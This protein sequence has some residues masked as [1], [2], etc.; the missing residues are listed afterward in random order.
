MSELSSLSELA[1]FSGRAGS[2]DPQRRRR[3]LRALTAQIDAQGPRRTVTE[4][5]GVVMTLSA[6]TRRLVL[7]PV[8]IDLDVFA[9]D[10][11][12]AVRLVLPRSS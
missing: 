1:S 6:R 9:P 12:R 4:L 10:G 2:P 5:L 11:G 3:A 8:G 7:P